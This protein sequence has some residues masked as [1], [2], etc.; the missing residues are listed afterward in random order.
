MPRVTVYRYK[1]YDINTDSTTIW[2][3]VGT[4]KAIAG[5][6]RAT[7]IESAASRFTSAARTRIW[8]GSR[9]RISFRKLRAELLAL[10]AALFSDIVSTDVCEAIC[11]EVHPDADEPAGD[12]IVDLEAKAV[13][14]GLNALNYVITKITDQYITAI[15]NKR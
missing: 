5:L 7:I 11:I 14:W 6:K 13:T 8:T 12:L 2:T 15:Q 10:R 3:R 4:R 9:Q 1:A